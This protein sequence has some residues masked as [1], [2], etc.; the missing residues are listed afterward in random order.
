MV[1]KN[2][3]VDLLIANISTMLINTYE[4]L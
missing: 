2:Y 1:K 4:K 3:Y